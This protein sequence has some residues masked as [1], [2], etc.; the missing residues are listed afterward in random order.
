MCSFMFIVIFVNKSGNYKLS[1]LDVRKNK[2]LLHLQH[3]EEC[4]RLTVGKIYF[5][6]LAPHVAVDLI[7]ATC[8]YQDTHDIFL[9]TD[10]FI[11][12]F[13]FQLIK[14]TIW[15]SAS[16]AF[17]YTGLFSCAVLPRTETFYSSIVDKIVHRQST[18]GGIGMQMRHI[19]I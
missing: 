12:L 10:V 2:Y 3:T 17:Y 18:S 6:R 13:P 7:E 11:I 16:A 9:P 8:K 1:K 14:Y 15:I 19:Y 5:H 4:S